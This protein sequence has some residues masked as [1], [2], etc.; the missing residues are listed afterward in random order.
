MHEN[1]LHIGRKCFTGR[2]NLRLAE[3]SLGESKKSAATLRATNEK[4]ISDN[5]RLTGENE[6]LLA[7]L[8]QLE[9]SSSSSSS[10]SDE[11]QEIEKVEGCGVGGV[12][13]YE[14]P[15]GWE[16]YSNFHQDILTLNSENIATSPDI[17]LDVSEAVTG[18]P[19]QVRVCLIP[20]QMYQENMTTKEIKSVRRVKIHKPDTDYPKY[21]E[22]KAPDKHAYAINIPKDDALFK[23]IEGK[24]FLLVVGVSSK[25]A[26][27][28]TCRQQNV[29]IL[30]CQANEVA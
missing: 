16:S 6:A 20:G 1:R 25:F 18:R 5:L 22:A 23:E 15:L 9:K 7:R 19:M 26:I 2:K 17:Y 12:W 30:C 3:Q 13:Q 8:Q 4:L 21:W 11:K 10:S 29:G 24:F 14:T 28:N 27:Y